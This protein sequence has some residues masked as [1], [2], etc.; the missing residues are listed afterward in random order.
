MPDY[1]YELEH[2]GL[3]AGIDEAGRGPLSGPVVAGAVVFLE[4][5]EEFF[6]KNLNDSKKLSE[7]KRNLLFEALTSSE[8]VFWGVGAVS[9]KEIDEINIRNAA[10]LAMKR[11]FAM[12]E[13]KLAKQ[14]QN[15][16]HV[17]ID[18]NDVPKIGAIPTQAVIK[19]DQISLSI[20]GAS[21]LAKVVRDRIMNKLTA[22]YPQ[23]GWDSNMGYPTKSHK[24]ALL[25]VG[26]CVH[27]RMSFRGVKS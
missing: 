22:R 23:Y 10:H 8:S 1:A 15:V 14:G 4:K 20:A 9:S 7:K 27:H 5:P 13:R 18:G 3:V 6:L 24:Q 11:A 19:G 26:P 12:L 21:V 17:L 16:I 25:E 2:D